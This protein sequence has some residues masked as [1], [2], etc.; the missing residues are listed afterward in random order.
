MKHLNEEELI[1]HH[2]GESDAKVEH[3]L[4]VCGECAQDYAALASDLAS[5]KAAEPPARDALYGEQVWR[6]LSSSLP[7]Y[8]IRRRSWLGVSLWQGVGYAAACVLIVCGAFLAGRQWEQGKPRAAANIGGQ[9][10]QQVVLVVLGD[11]LDRSERLLIELKHADASNADIVSPL[12]EEARNLLA[13]N[14]L[15]RQSAVQ[16]DDPTLATSLDHLGRV[17]A[18]LADE[19]GG[20][21]SSTIVRLQNEMNRDGLLFEIRVLRSRVPD[22]QPGGA[23]QPHGG[24]I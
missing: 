15:C 9:S 3:H 17:L 5:L 10:K 12:R 24:T 18:E 22:Q 2:Y 23:S 20:V 8:A 19:P 16:I 1:E 4:Q 13:A 11:H 7:A 21:S 6:S 14:R